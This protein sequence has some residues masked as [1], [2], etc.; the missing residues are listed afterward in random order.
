M[1][2]IKRQTTKSEKKMTANEMREELLIT[3]IRNFLRKENFGELYSLYRDG[4][5]T[6][7]DF[8]NELKDNENKYVVDMSEDVS[9]E[10]L[11]VVIE[12]VA[13]IGLDIRELSTSDVAEMF[14]LKP[15]DAKL[16]PSHE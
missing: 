15:F 1:V 7:A 5:I 6:E 14:S 13:K 2:L 10:K 11:A 12:L 8:T 3:A 4:Y 16:F 9:D